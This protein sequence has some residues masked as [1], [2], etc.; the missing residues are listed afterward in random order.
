MLMPWLSRPDPGPSIPDMETVY[1]ASES[2]ITAGDYV[3]QGGGNR[4]TF[5]ASERTS[6]T[7]Y[8]VLPTRR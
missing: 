1:Y 3:I 2:G 8:R 4:S 6:E 5:V 7:D